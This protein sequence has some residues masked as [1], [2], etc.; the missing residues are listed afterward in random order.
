MRWFIGMLVQAAMLAGP[1]VAQAAPPVTT[2]ALDHPS[3]APV[4]VTVTLTAADAASTWF[5]TGSGFVRYDG[6]VTVA[7]EGW[8]TVAFYSIDE[9]GDQEDERSVSFRIDRT[10]PRTAASPAAGQYAGPVSVRLA[11]SDPGGSGVALTFGRPRTR[12]FAARGLTVKVRCAR[13]GTGRATLD[14]SRATARRLK[15][16]GQRLASRAVR[17]AAGRTPTVR[18]KP[19][20]RIA[21]RVARRGVRSLKATLQVT[22]RGEPALRRSLTLRR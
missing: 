19:S 7:A 21:K 5:N 16:R 2:A 4:P 22:L 11:A 13:A 3:P 8:H 17:C 18:L 14:V 9:S 20:K 12:A 1:A 15:L 6:P 10:S